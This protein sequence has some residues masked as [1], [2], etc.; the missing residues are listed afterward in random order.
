VLFPA[1]Q[2]I[3]PSHSPVIR[4]MVAPI[5]SARYF[6][7]KNGERV[8]TA[9]AAENQQ[10]HSGVITSPLSYAARLWPGTSAQSTALTS[11]RSLSLLELI[12]GW[13]VGL[14]GT[15]LLR[16]MLAQREG[17]GCRRNDWE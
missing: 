5:G 9:V 17:A 1:A 10:T 4:A 15:R 8:C 16:Q 13:Q 14:R 7:A 11:A 2:G 3:S 6:C 12:V